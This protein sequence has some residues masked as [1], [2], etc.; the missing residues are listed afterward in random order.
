MQKCSEKHSKYVYINT[1]LGFNLD[2]KLVTFF[3]LPLSASK[4]LHVC[5]SAVRHFHVTILAV[6]ST[7]L[8]RVFSP[9]MLLHL[10]S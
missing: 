1:F 5:I 10:F 7:I 8:F 9:L 3:P 2:G 6:L 4:S